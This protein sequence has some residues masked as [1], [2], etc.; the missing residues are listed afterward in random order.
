VKTLQISNINEEVIPKY[1]RTKENK[2]KEYFLKS[3][4]KY[5]HSQKKSLSCS[6]DEQLYNLLLGY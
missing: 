5:R 3:T 4:R 1:K 2:R 6:F